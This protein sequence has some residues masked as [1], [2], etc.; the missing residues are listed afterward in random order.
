MSSMTLVLGSGFAGRR[1]RFGCRAG[2]RLLENCLERLQQV[3]PVKQKLGQ[4]EFS[5]RRET[6]EALV[7]LVLLAPLAGEETLALEAAQQRV[8]RALIHRY[9]IFFQ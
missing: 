4:D 8:E 9:P 6:I 2:L 1:P 3:F 5:L 7:A